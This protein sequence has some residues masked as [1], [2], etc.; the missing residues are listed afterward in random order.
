MTVQCKL[1]QERL[2]KLLDSVISSLL[3][4]LC[5]TLTPFT[6]AGTQLHSDSGDLQVSV[7]A[8]VSGDRKGEGDTA[9]LLAHLQLLLLFKGGKEKTVLLSRINSS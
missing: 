5:K 2:G 9:A 7:R 4:F 6:Q 1:P 3:L 8:A